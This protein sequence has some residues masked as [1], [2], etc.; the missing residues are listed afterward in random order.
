M[1]KYHYA[2]TTTSTYMQKHGSRGQAINHWGPKS[3]L[4]PIYVILVEF[5]LFYGSKHIFPWV[6]DYCGDSD[7]QFILNLDSKA[8][9]E[10][11]Q[12]QVTTD[13]RPWGSTQILIIC[14]LKTRLSSLFRKL[15]GPGPLWPPCV[16]RCP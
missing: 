14:F 16:T 9:T 12:P 5:T 6:F 8:V 7:S 11:P 1:I 2:L 10:L 15:V 4:C 13:L 3:I